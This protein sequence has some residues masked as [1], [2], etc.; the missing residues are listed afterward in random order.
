VARQAVKTSPSE[1]IKASRRVKA[2]ANGVRAKGLKARAMGKPK[3]GDLASV[4]P[5]VRRPNVSVAEVLL[6]PDANKSLVCVS[7]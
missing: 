2:K 3:S 7:E 1:T 4:A 5:L 6:A